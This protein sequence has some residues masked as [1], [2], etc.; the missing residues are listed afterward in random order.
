MVKKQAWTCQF[1]VPEI[2]IIF[3]LLYWL[4][5]NVVICTNYSIR[6]SRDDTF[7]DNIRRYADCMAGGIHNYDDCHELRTDLETEIN[8]VLEVLNYIF[9]AL[10]NFAS[11]PFVV[12]F[13]TMKKSV[14]R[15]TSKLN[16]KPTTI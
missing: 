9:I 6:A 1:T 16:S 2:K 11:L 5:T 15:A 3:V 12:Q 14:Q 7:H 4:I 10:L 13:E 8:P